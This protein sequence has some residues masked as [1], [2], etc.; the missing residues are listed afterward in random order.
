MDYI[1]KLKID[2]NKS[3]D[4]TYRNIKINNND[5]TIIYIDSIISSDKISDFIIRS[6]NNIK[7][8]ITLNNIYNNIS[9]FK[10]VEG[11]TY[12]KLCFYLNNGFTILLLNNEKIFLAF[13]TKSNSERGITLPSTEQS[14]RGS[15][16]SFTENY[17]TN[18]GLIKKRIKNN[19]LWIENVIKGK[20]TN[21]NISI[22]YINGIVKKELVKK[23]L[24]KLKKIDMDGIITI[25]SIKNILSNTTNNIL[26][27]VQTTE[28]PD[29]VSTSL[30]KGKIAIIVDNNP[31]II[32]IPTVLND[33]FKTIEDEYVN[34]INA[35]FT[36]TLKVICFFIS[37][38]T[39]GIYIALINYNP[40]M[41]PTSLLVNMIIQRNSVPFPAFFEA[42]IM[43]LA[44][45]ILREAD[46]RVPSFSGSALSIVGALIIGDALVNA[47]IASPIIITITAITAISSL[48]FTEFELINS[49]RWYRLLFMLGGSLF[50]IIGILIVFLLFITKLSYMESFGMPYLLPYVPFDKH[51]I[52]D[53][54]YKSD[55]KNTNERPRYLSNNSIKQRNDKN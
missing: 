4:I 9:I 33:F 12:E 39:P 46:L 31:Y 52:K 35:S 11:N 29:V 30:L 42:F 1:E 22:L 47:G 43:M 6:L 37:I 14:V 21:T 7:D 8:N 49:L 55:I 41:I 25:G 45:E 15:K 51:D 27:T 28:R 19:N 26:P 32:L 36:R 54:I 50:G 2:T 18:I 23:V 53:S 3:S 44:F 34:H 16:D 40:E 13:E 38:L 5:I 48:P 10:V 24:K 20:Y 17:Q